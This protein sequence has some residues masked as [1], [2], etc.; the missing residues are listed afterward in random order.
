[1]AKINRDDLDRFFV[2]GVM[3]S[4]RT[5]YIGEV[6]ADDPEISP[7]MDYRLA[8]RVIKGLIALEA[9]SQ[10][11][12]TLIINNPGGDEYQ[13]LAIYDAIRACG[14][15][16]EARVI[17]HA[18]SMGAWITQAADHRII[19]PS[20]TMMIHYG[21]MGT[22]GHAIDFERWADESKRLNKL[23]EQHFLERIREKN[24]K[25][26]LK[27]LQELLK[28]DTILGPKE[29]LDLGLIDEIFEFPE[30]N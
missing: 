18:M 10:D 19:Y 17:G 13:G 8:D 22:W 23:E 20:A 9:I 27:K 3:P 12:I 15:P 5:L 1:M 4:Q 14:S 6:P 7:G 29:C 21:T 16:T 11:P 2:F 30:R 24:P 25:Y 26:P 28:F